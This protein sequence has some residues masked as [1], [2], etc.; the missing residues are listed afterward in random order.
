MT[1]TP[2][3]SWTPIEY[4]VIDSLNRCNRQDDTTMRDLGP[5]QVRPEMTPA[6][7]EDNG[8]LELRPK[9]SGSR[10]T[11][12]S[13]HSEDQHELSPSKQRSQRL[14][15]LEEEAQIAHSWLKLAKKLFDKMR[16]RWVL[17]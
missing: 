15:K 3:I 2:E 4:D 17:Q 12:S 13:C 7:E 8:R 6:I 10:R 5:Q 1:N 9:V 14:Q 11:Q 16:Y